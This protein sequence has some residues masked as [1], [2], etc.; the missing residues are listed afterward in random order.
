MG[1]SVRDY[2]DVI[3]TAIAQ[4]RLVAMLSGFFGALATL[5]AGIG[6]Y[7]VTAYAVSRR[8]AEFAIRMA[9]GAD[10]RTV[11]RL[12]LR[13]VAA[14]V[15]CGAAIGLALTLWASKFVTALLFGV[16]AR[17]PITM[18]TA[19][20]LLMVVALIAGY[21]PARRATQLDPNAVLRR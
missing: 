14:V 11:V 13:S 21:M 20:A 12:V 8:S 9:L 19:L 16:E 18:A 2:S 15:V 10:R 1:F 7:G 17:D 3:G 4:E 6:L 5:L